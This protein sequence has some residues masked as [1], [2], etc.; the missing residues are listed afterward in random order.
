MKRM[1]RRSHLLQQNRAFFLRSR[2]PRFII[3]LSLIGLVVVLVAAFGAYWWWNRWQDTHFQSYEPTVMPAGL[4]TMTQTVMTD[5]NSERYVKM[6]YIQ[7][8]DPRINIVQRSLHA[9]KTSKIAN[10]LCADATSA[11]QELHTPK[12]APYYINIQYARGQPFTKAVSW[13]TGSTL[14]RIVMGPHTLM[15]FPD[16]GWGEMIDSYVPT[17]YGNRPARS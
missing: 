6:V 9:G 5:P 11:C 12:G 16:D 3:T 10:P 17:D 14:S 4:H 1:K 7:T 15:L 13:T 2:K 8:T